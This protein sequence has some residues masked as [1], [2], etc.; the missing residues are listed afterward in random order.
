MALHRRIAAEEHLKA[1]IE[2]EPVGRDI[3]ADA[4]AR[5]RVAVEQQK[6]LAS[7]VQH[8]SGCKAARP[9]ADN[10]DHG[11]SSTALI[12]AISIREPIRRSPDANEAG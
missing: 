2:A 5:R 10:H 8:T 1:S 7:T 3:R 9:R 6:G 11:G 12:G 4:T